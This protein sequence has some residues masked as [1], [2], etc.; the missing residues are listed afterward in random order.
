MTGE[1]LRNF[2]IPLVMFI[3]IYAIIGMQLYANRLRF[4]ALGRHIPA[5]NS[6]EWLNAPDRPLIN[7]D[8]FPH[9]FAAVFQILTFDDWNSVYVNLWRA[10][11][12]SSLI[13]SFSLVSFGVYV[14]MNLFL[15]ILLG[16]FGMD[17]DEVDHGHEEEV[18]VE[19]R[20]EGV[21]ISSRSDLNENDKSENGRIVGR[22]NAAD[23]GIADEEAGTAPA[24]LPPAGA[25]SSANGANIVQKISETSGL[26]K[27]CVEILGYSWFSHCTLACTIVSSLALAFDNPLSDPNGNEQ[28]ALQCID[29]IVTVFFAVEA[30]LKVLAFNFWDSSPDCYVKDPWNLM[31][32]F[33]LVISFISIAGNDPVVSQKIKGLRALR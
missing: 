7:F 26:K 29:I 10:A 6:E 3:F 12:P 33:I 17:D 8:D 13:Y 15:A 9:A 32:L 31:D 27:K 14:L 5:I 1:D 11:G 23:A 16:N 18:V 30:S 2:G 22:D 4:D 24:I 21:G 25:L 28:Y 20:T 19:S